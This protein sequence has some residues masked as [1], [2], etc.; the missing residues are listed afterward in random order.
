MQ[1]RRYWLRLLALTLVA[2]VAALMV[3]PVG[4]GVLLMS[5]LTHPACTLSADPARAD[6]TFEDIRFQSPRGLALRGFFMPGTNGATVI[7]VPA[8]ANDRG[9]DLPDAALLNRAGFNVLT[10]DSPV[11][12]GAA[13]HTLGVAEADDVLA[14]YDY[15]R[16]R[17][18]VD[19]GRISLHGFSSA[20]STSLF[21]AARLPALRAVS[22]MGGYHNL[23]EQLGLGQENGLLHRLMM[24][25]A[26]VGYRLSTGLDVRSLSPLAVIDRIAPRPILLIYG[27]R[28][29]S[30]PGAR[31]M[32]DRARSG[33]G[34]A[35]L[36]VVE[37]ASHGNYHDIAG[38]AY[39]QRLVA[40]HRAALLDEQPPR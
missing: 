13:V 10:F 39:Q 30:L 31:Q 4:L 36:W 8:Y 5:G 37:G 21:A 33:G 24:V 1:T 6:L 15:L 22:A 20:G 28:E 9:G 25:G 7:V 40:F 29:V 11:C 12:A 16:T 14:A 3:L 23:S 17:P 27:S 34:S 38:S 26:E 35:E 2:L 18:D 32:L 19:P